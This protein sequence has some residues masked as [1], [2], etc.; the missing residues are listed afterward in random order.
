MNEQGPP[1]RTE[2]IAS[3]QKPTQPEPPI[4][5]VLKVIPGTL[6]I[7]QLT[8][9]RMAAMPYASD[10]L[11]QMTG[12]RPDEVAENAAP[13]IDRIHPQ[14]IK[15]FFT[16]AEESAKTMSP[17][18]LEFR[19]GHPDKR[20]VWIEWQA[21]PILQNGR[22][23]W[24]GM[25]LDITERKTMQWR[26]ELLE[27]ALNQSTDE[28]F[29]INEELRFEYVNDATCNDLGYNREELLNMRPMDID[30]ELDPDT[31]SAMMQRILDG[32]SLS[33]E[34]QHRTKDGELIPVEI[35]GALVEFG[36]RCFS[37]TIARDISERRRMLE[38]L[39]HS[40][41][42][43]RHLVENLPDHIARW[44]T[45]GRYL[46]INPI[47]ESCIPFSTE[48]VLGKTISE[49]FPGSCRELESCAASVAA[50]GEPVT[51]QRLTLT[52]LNGEILFH[53]LKLVPEFDDNGRVTSVLSLGRDMTNYYRAQEIITANEREMRLLHRAINVSSD[54]IFVLDQ[55]FHFVSVNDTACRSLG[56][57]SDELVGMTPLDI[58]PDVTQEALEKIAQDVD[59]LGSNRTFMFEAR[60]RTK[61]GSIFP[62]EIAS[63]SFIEGGQRYAINIVRD[64]SERKRAEQALLLSEQAFRSLTE[65]I[66]DNV[67]RW[68]TQGRYLYLNPTHEHTLETHAEDLIG[69][70]IGEAFPNLFPQVEA[71]IARVINSGH[72]TVVQHQPVPAGEDEIRLH[73]IKMVPEFDDDGRVISV[74]ALGR[75][76]TDLYRL[77]EAVTTSEQAFR[78]LAENLP[79]LVIRYDEKCRRTFISPNYK[80]F[81][82]MIIQ[83]AL[84]KSPLE[85]WLVPSDRQAAAQFQAHLQQALDSGRPEKWESVSPNADGEITTLEFY[86][87]PEFDSDGRITGVLAV[88]RD[89]TSRRAMEQ[90]LRT[91]ASVFETA[92]E[93]IIIT[94]PRGYIYDTNPAFT[95]ITG[96]TRSEVLG[97]RPSM[98]AQ[99]Q[100]T[101]SFYRKLWSSLRKEGSWSGETVNRRKNGER[102]YLQLNVMTIHN[103]SGN[104]SYYIAIFSDITQL[105]LHEQQL[106][107]IAYHDALTGLPNRH[108]LSK[109]L[110][111]AITQA[112]HSGKMLAVLYLDLDS[113]KPINDNF[114]HEMGDRVL[115][116]IAHRLSDSLRDNDTVARLGGD[117]FIALLTK[118]SDHSECELTAHRLLDRIAQPIIL[119]EHRLYLSASIGISRYPD[120]GSVDTD[121]L[122]RYADQ[123][124]YQ[125]KAAGRNQFLFYG[126][127][128]RNQALSNTQIIHDLRSALDQ[129]QISV[130]YQPIIHMVTGQVVKAEALARW[131]HPEQ[132][133]IPPSEFIPAAENSGLIQQIGDL[134]FEQ[135]VSVAQILNKHTSSPPGEPMRISV[136]L[137]P[138]QFFHRDG[139]SNWVQHLTDRNIS[140]ELLT[141][142]ITEGL[143]LEDRPEVLQQLNQLRGMGITIS[144]D[145][146]GTGYSALS[147]LKKFDID[148]LKI[149][150][151][152]ICH[153]IDDPNDRAIVEAI[154]VMA[155]RLDIKLVA[156]GVETRSQAALL[157]AADCDM[158][159]GFWYA[160]PMPE[161]EFLAF[162]SQ[163]R[164]SI[165]SPG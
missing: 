163:S 52:G 161:A 63:S 75:D 15:P 104:P 139:V 39:Q 162:V 3:V 78:S 94:D 66:P 158:A 61:D 111:Q 38:E 148:Y 62:V 113:F 140:G 49:L 76:M 60:H 10:R 151:S 109:N 119:D 74:L 98:L 18:H 150:R 19:L 53:D 103:E 145:D 64:I 136:N 81:T 14:D 123:A 79:D 101:R 125:A 159:Q 58:D 71:G 45:E 1:G 82:G 91:A 87:A 90:Q 127:N 129:E 88:G 118:I 132:G 122:L 35:N 20:E 141:V 100:D 17:W 128:P 115:V 25:L 16:S 146:F 51:L 147:Y 154:I 31:A 21:T 105:K 23:F 155:K 164:S 131:E 12:F 5:E 114:G 130:H 99:E 107:H 13:L 57:S 95:S 92:K 41:L 84:G 97:Q 6:F 83:E 59:M 89:I 143:L 32:D 55:Q 85:H 110:S 43:Y 86:A 8:G 29:L 93:G 116:E 117:E 153:I 108:L 80:H 124:M 160:K 30:P 48:E 65:N 34:T 68:D 144:L 70:P 72:P 4:F 138:R 137:S 135:S 33:F 22:L 67:V 149:D 44:D 56:Y 42:A 152:F 9:K 27:D 11:P 2:T 121:M 133:M 69:K 7:F 40:E 142:E 37:L 24:H 112:R 165:W 26:L 46:Y 73:D 36:G 102:Y 77:Q 156:E 157:A 96:Y 120:D 54:G 50:T 28:I 126:D 134:V 106:Q 47:L